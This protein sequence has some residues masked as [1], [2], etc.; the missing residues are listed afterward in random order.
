MSIRFK[1]AQVSNAVTPS[2]NLW[3]YITGTAGDIEL[4]DPAGVTGINAENP[5]NTKLALFLST[6]LGNAASASIYR[7]GNKLGYTGVVQ[8]VLKYNAGSVMQDIVTGEYAESVVT[9]SFDVVEGVY[10]A[11]ADEVTREVNSFGFTLNVTD[12]VLNDAV[13][14]TRLNNLEEIL[15]IVGGTT[16]GRFYMDATDNRL[17]KLTA[18]GAMYITQV[19]DGAGAGKDYMEM[20]LQSDSL[21]NAVSN[22]VVEDYAL[23]QYAD[24]PAG[25]NNRMQIKTRIDRAAVEFNDAPQFA[26][27]NDGKLLTNQFVAVV[28]V[29]APNGHI[30]VR[31]MAGTIVAKIPT[32]AP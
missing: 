32:V 29:G 22:G 13:E 12:T 15:L 5:A 19:E 3:K 18:N 8:D 16:V 30:E 14:E 31:D 25:A 10:A 23:S 2:T 21:D 4:N 26:V 24:D 7:D 27:L 9:N 11:V 17:E 28:P 6:L 20:L 1:P